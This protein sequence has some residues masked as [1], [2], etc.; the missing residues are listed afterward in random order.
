M[1][2]IHFHANLMWVAV[3]ALVCICAACQ[4]QVNISPTIA[5]RTVVP[6][7]VT[8]TATV[9]LTVT[10]TT[11][12]ISTPTTAQP[13]IAISAVTPVVVQTP[14]S[15]NTG[16]Q[17]TPTSPVTTAT[18]GKPSIH[19]IAFLVEL[20][21][22]RYT[23]CFLKDDNN[24]LDC[25]ADDYQDIITFAWSPTALEIAFR[26]EDKILVAN[27]PDKKVTQLALAYGGTSLAWSPDGSKIAFDCKIGDNQ[28]IC[29]VDRTGENMI[30]LT[31]SPGKD[32]IVEWSPD[33]TKITLGCRINGN[34]EICVI[35]STGENMIQL[36]SSQGEDLV[37][38]WSPDGTKLVFLSDRG[39]PTPDPKDEG[40][41]DI[42]H[43]IWVMNAD[44]S[45]PRRLTDGQPQSR[46]LAPVWSP[47]GRYLAFLSGRADA[48]HGYQESIHVVEADGTPVLN[49]SGSNH[50]GFPYWSADSLRLLFE[51]V[52]NNQIII[53]S[54]Q[55]NRELFRWSYSEEA[56]ISQR[57]LCTWSPD[58]TQIAC[59][60][61]S[62]VCIWEN[63]GEKI[64]IV[65]IPQH[66]FI[67]ETKWAPQKKS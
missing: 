8:P 48:Q 7:S 3:I 44:G 32:S 52:Q 46:N 59:W 28:E 16:H 25:L 10:L 45:D 36:T 26:A 30:Q 47:N 49:I 12:V 24:T 9:L 55:E 63:I 41:G 40:M 53:V 13:T 61:I 11:T 22:D 17:P 23:I 65:E 19:S 58:S 60:C 27:V 33:G 34:Q 43:D 4:L 66:F 6:A 64:A 20:G 2:T 57:N 54:V 31:N 56:I 5:S 67:I 37:K 42:E 18:P 21:T 62:T 14:T 38:G 50:M 39:R 1:K 15:T 35:D 29:V 51:D